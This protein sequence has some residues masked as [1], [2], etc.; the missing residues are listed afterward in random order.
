MQRS[1]LHDAEHDGKHVGVELLEKHGLW[2]IIKLKQYP[3]RTIKCTTLD[4]NYVEILRKGILKHF[5]AI[6]YYNL[7]DAEIKF[8]KIYKRFLTIIFLISWA[9]L[10]S[11][12]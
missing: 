4:F 11:S 3:L 8:E 12:D 1:A 5:M 9:Q 7:S 2:H 6:K 10:S